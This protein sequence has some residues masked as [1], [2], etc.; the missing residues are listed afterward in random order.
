MRSHVARSSQLDLL[1][2]RIQSYIKLARAASSAFRK[3]APTALTE[4]PISSNAIT[5][6][7]RFDALRLSS[8]ICRAFSM[9]KCLG[10]ATERKPLPRWNN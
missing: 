8:R 3:S 7:M 2:A 1:A 9:G 6:S 10:D 5:C 4:R